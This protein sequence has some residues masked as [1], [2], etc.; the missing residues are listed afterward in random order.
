MSNHNLL[1][2][3]NHLIIPEELFLLS[4][5]HT[6]G[7]VTKM[8]TKAFQF[9]L[10]SSI[11]MEL[12]LLGKIDTDTD[13]LII[14]DTEPIGSEVLDM[15]LNEMQLHAGVQNM[16]YWLNKLNERYETFVYALLN[17]LIRKNMLKIEHQ[18]V[19]WVFSKLMYP[20]VG[21]EEVKDVKV[22]VRELIFSDELPELHD[23]AVVS[24]LYYSGLSYFIFSQ[25]EM[26]SKRNRVEMIAKMD[27]LGQH[28]GERLKQELDLAMAMA[29]SVMIQ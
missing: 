2:M 18:K 15:A 29:G 10:S 1:T 9:A 19:L 20:I 5:D 25:S 24:L 28:V 7:N 13:G 22:R 21:K 26:D 17:G 8:Q 3:N 14:V 16:N 12:A 6:G 27:L 11:L 23:M 4:I